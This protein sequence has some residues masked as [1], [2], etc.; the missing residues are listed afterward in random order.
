MRSEAG[1]HFPAT[2]STGGA[3]ANRIVAWQSSTPDEENRPN[4]QDL[5]SQ[6]AFESVL[7]NSDRADRL[8]DEM[9]LQNVSMGDR[10]ALAALFRRYARLVRAVAYRILRNEA[11]ADDLLQEV[12]LFIF[13]KAELFDSTRGSARSWIV[14]LTYHRAIDRRRYLGSRHFYDALDLD[15]TAVARLATEVVCYERSLEGALGRATLQRI[16]CSLSA[17]QRETLRL[18]FFEGFTIEE[19]ARKMGQSSGNVR[20]HYYRALEKMRKLLFAR[21]LSVE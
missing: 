18:Y 4:D 3:A 1:S 12:F 9:L 2:I 20:N 17:D 7:D 5:L 8:S 19:V 14:Q 15:G 21:K 11:E 16:D 6:I 13:R 10:E